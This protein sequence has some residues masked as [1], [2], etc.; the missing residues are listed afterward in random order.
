M[1]LG[2]MAP[3]ATTPGA[4]LEGSNVGPELTPGFVVS[5]IGLIAPGRAA[6]PVPLFPELGFGGA[7]GPPA[8]GGTLEADG[9]FV[10][11]LEGMPPVEGPGAFG[12]VI[13]LAP[14]EPIPDL[15][16]PDP[17]PPAPPPPPAA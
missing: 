11:V 15:A 3:G 2:P 8:I 1:P 16:A 6:A 5:N 7:G 10:G 12:V 13:P 14:L 9:A 17:T 4:T